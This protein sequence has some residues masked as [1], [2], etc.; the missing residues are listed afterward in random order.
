MIEKLLESI[1]KTNPFGEKVTLVAAVKLQTPENINRAIKAGITDIGDNHVQ[2]FK[3]KFDLI[4]GNPRRHFIGH[5]QTNKIKYLVGKVDL[6]HSVD[7]LPLAEALSA[8]SEM[9]G[10]TSDILLQINIG[11]EE[12]KGG[13]SYGDAGDA[14]RRTKALP[15]LRIKGLMAM[16]PLSSDE[17][18]L[19]ALARK[20]R[21]LYESLMDENFEY[22][23]MG[24]SGDYELCI[25]AGSNLIRLGT[26]IFGERNYEKGK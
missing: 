11:D 7:R 18:T 3:D 1:P 6:Y 20:M 8:R 9:A 23:S 5:L 25:N 2:E 22:L 12:T 26:A 15:A 13:F 4:E 24:M 10:V 17:E 16:L 21:G 19:S 14:Y